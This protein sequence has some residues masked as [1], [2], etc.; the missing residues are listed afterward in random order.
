MSRVFLFLLLVS[1]SWAQTPGN[2]LDKAPPDVDEALRDRI[3]RFY[4]A[5][6]DRK[7]IRQADQYV[8]EDTKDFFFESNKP[9]YLEFK[10][11]KIIY[12]EN[13]TKAKAIVNCKMIVPMP[14]FG[15]TPMTVPAP[16][17]WK[18]ENG[19]WVWYV[20][21]TLGRET[22]FGRMKPAEGATPGGGLPSL[23]SGPDIQA[24][25]KSV[26]ADKNSVQLS[27]S[28]ESSDEVTISNKMP[29]SI[30][31]RLDYAKTQGLEIGLDR[32]ELKPGEQARI[33]LRFQPQKRPA[34][35]T[36]EV[37]VM[38]EPTNQMIPIAVTF[39]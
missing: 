23:A 13:F 8:A 15:N 36:A 20:D 30:S 31:L 5:H 29:G 16:S 7:L 27:A 38:V 3:T 11:D 10:I 9:N 17:T 35:K 24:L 14:G 12:S 32:T 37:R 34:P 2:L 1:G 39:Q 4:Q 6:V 21:Q 19:Q 22:P 33:R 28:Q 18:I 25:W 26:R